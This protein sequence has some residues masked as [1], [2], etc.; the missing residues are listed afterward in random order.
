MPKQHI[1]TLKMATAM[2]SETLDN[3]QH[4]TWLTPESRSCTLISS[5]E[6]SRTRMQLKNSHFRS[7]ADIKSNVM[8]VLKRL[9]VNMYSSVCRHG[10]GAYVDQVKSEF[11]FIYIL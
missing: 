6:N 8:S 10:R 1:V 4:L 2:F 3:Y 11:E 5:C 7:L 9:W